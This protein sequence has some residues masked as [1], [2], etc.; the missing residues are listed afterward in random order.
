MEILKRRAGDVIAAG[1]ALVC[2]HVF[3]VALLLDEP[4]PEKQ[5]HGFARLLGRNGRVDHAAQAGEI[6]F[7]FVQVYKRTDRAVVPVGKD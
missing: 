1:D 4:K 2:E 6:A 3:A 5:V 7:E